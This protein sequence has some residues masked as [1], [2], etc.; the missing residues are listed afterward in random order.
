MSQAPA[1]KQHFVAID[2]RSRVAFAEMF[3]DE[4]KRSAAMFLDHAAGTIVTWECRYAAS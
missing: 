2:D 4:R 3:A 1:T